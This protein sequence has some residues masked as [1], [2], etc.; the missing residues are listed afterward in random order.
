MVFLYLFCILP[1]LMC[2]SYFLQINALLKSC[3][4]S[5]SQPIWMPKLMQSYLETSKKQDKRH[6]FLFSLIPADNIG[7]KE[8]IDI[9]KESN[10]CSVNK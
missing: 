3:Q 6:I 4:N 5:I 8:L 10:C 9:L 2:Y 1:L 7:S